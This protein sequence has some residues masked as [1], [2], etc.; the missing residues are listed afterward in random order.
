MRRGVS[1]TLKSL[2][3]EESGQ[4]LVKYLLVLPFVAFGVTA[5]M[6]SLASGVNSEFSKISTYSGTYIS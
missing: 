3:R 1:K 2:Y 5:G 4:G 6:Q